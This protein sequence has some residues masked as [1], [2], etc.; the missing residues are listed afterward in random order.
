MLGDDFWDQKGSVHKVVDSAIPTRARLTLPATL[1]TLKNIKDGGKNTVGVFAKKIVQVRTQFGPFMA[2]VSS[3]VKKEVK[4]KEATTVWKKK[5]AMYK[6]QETTTLVN[7]MGTHPNVHQQVQQ[8]QS[9][10]QQQQQIFTPEQLHQLQ[11]QHHANQHQQQSL[12]HQSHQLGHRTPHQQHLEQQ[13]QHQQVE[14]QTAQIHQLQ[15]QTQLHQQ[16]QHHFHHQPVHMDNHNQNAMTAVTVAQ[17]LL[18]S[19]ALDANLHHIV[20]SEFGQPLGFPSP[21]NTI[22]ISQEALQTLQNQFQAGFVQTRDGVEFHTD[23][24][25]FT[26]AM[27]SMVAA[28]NQDGMSLPVTISIPQESM[29]S[30]VNSVTET[31][32]RDV[33]DSGVGDM[34]QATQSDN[35]AI[36]ID[37]DDPQDEVNE[38]DMKWELK[39]FRD[40]GYVESLDFSDEDKCNW[41]MFVRPART[42][43]E[44]NL[45]ATQQE[46][47]LFFITTKPIPSN[48]ELKVWYA[49][50]Y[51]KQMNKPLL[52]EEIEEE[53][54]GSS[55]SCSVCNGTFPSFI[56]LESHD[57]ISKPSARRVS[58]R[59]KGRPRKYVKP[60]KT[61]R[62][63]L[64]KTRLKESFSQQKKEGLRKRGRPRTRPLVPPPPP[65]KEEK[66]EDSPNEVEEPEEFKEVKPPK[67]LKPPKEKKKRGPKK[68]RDPYQCPHC[69]EKFVA[70]A[71]Y[72]IHVYQHTGIKPFICEVEA[73]NK[74]FMSKFKLE[75]HCLIH[76][77][78]RHHKCPYCDKSFN[79]KDHLKNHLITHDPNKKIWKCELCGK[80]YSYNFSYRT[81]MAFHAAE[82]GQTLVCQICKKEA[83]TKEELLFHLKIHTGAR[84]AKSL[85]EKTHQCF[86]CGKKFFTR[87]DVKRH[88]ITHTK[89]KDFLCQY[90]PQR[91]GRKD[92]LTRHLRTSH[93]GDNSHTRHRRSH[94]EGIVRKREKHQLYEK[95]DPTMVAIQTPVATSEEEQVLAAATSMASQVLH[96]LSYVSGNVIQPHVNSREIQ[97]STLYDTTNAQTIPNIANLQAPP[98][99]PTVHTS[100][101]PTHYTINEKYILTP[102]NTTIRQSVDQTMDYRNITHATPV[103]NMYINPGQQHQVMI[104]KEQPNLDLTRSNGVLQTAD[105]Q[106]QRDQNTRTSVLHTSDPRQNQT[107]STLLGYMET[108]RFLENLPTNNTQTIPMQQIQ[109]VDVSQAALHAGNMLPVTAYSS[110]AT[111]V[112]N[113]N[114][115]AKA[116]PI[117]HTHHVT[118]QH[119]QGT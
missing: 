107:F 10:E 72:Y 104:N 113:I 102:Q 3:R 13:I 50:D 8:I 47:K 111:S 118:Y 33:D 38:Q 24:E 1:L 7:E 74:G 25:T 41:M 115:L 112:Q 63:K 16:H 59:R 71:A 90:C 21:E 49:A 27:N 84:A 44:Q 39:V 42:F 37:M 87:K 68:T 48:T 96:N 29:A 101:G 76:T 11:L 99:M 31:E 4:K 23:A 40:E 81:H 64:E 17:S 95:L 15:H 119:Q 66:L 14:H 83:L 114:E 80:E 6:A 60:T 105:Y 5:N 34:S 28:Q 94:G 12:E 53:A 18:A 2:P 9:S 43:K 108:L 117:T 89:K 36:E 30:A 77:S 20:V 67:E 62:Q 79:R 91:F 65:E 69:E 97:I 109:T 110:A 54:G 32:N 57:C 78:P 45:I 73:C 106:Q 56:D 86:E 46:G 70:E 58:G 98:G 55:W 52:L 51:A 82:S 75:R 19:A 35:A 100:S 88:M 116:I 93:T 103:A 22:H 61:W 26:A 92:H 85:T